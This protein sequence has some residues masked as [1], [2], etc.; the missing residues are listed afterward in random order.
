MADFKLKPLADRLIIE[1]EDEGQ[2]RTATGLYIPE[3][4]K[5][6]PQRGHV[7]AVGPGARNEDGERIPMDVQEGDTILFG[8]YAGTDI[9]L[10]GTE[11]KIMRE[12]DV[13]AIIEEK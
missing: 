2:G 6:K 9:K 5:D 12:S 13:L 8:K 1:I 3:T 7:I 10:N 11:V 4:A